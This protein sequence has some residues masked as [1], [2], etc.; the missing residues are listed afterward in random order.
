M[1]RHRASRLIS[2]ASADAILGV[3]LFADI[4]PGQFGKFNR[5][6]VTLFRIAAGDTWIDPLPTLGPDGDLEWKPALFVCSFIVISVWVVLQVSVAVLLDNFVSVSMRME[7][8]EKMRAAKEMKASSQFQSPLE[9][10]VAKLS[11]EYTDDANLS[12]N[13]ASLFQ[14]R[15]S[16]FCPGILINTDG[17]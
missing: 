4:A 7:N 13:L 16:A 9:P 12:S 17:R 14:V 8:D 3:S 1:V 11:N 2:R 10:L 5:A 6:F 15:P